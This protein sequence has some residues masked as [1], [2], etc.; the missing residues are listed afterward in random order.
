MI[1]KHVIVEDYY[2]VS[3]YIYEKYYLARFIKDFYESY[4]VRRKA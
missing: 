2:K 1:T 3:K 4:G